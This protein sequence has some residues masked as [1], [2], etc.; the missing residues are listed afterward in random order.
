MLYLETETI[1]REIHI[2]RVARVDFCEERNSQCLVV[3][4]RDLVSDALYVL[5]MEK[6]KEYASDEKNHFELG[7][8]K[9]ILDEIL[10]M[11]HAS[12][13]TLQTSR[14]CSFGDCE[15]WYSSFLTPISNEEA[16]SL[17]GKFS[18]LCV[19]EI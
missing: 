6:A 12:I 11:K 19:V 1:V 14:K 13:S 8:V 10:H 9:R 2:T 3:E 17:N 16:L 7:Y 4:R 5:D 18:C 15:D